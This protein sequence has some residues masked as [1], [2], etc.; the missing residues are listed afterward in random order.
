MTKSGMSRRQRARVRYM[1]PDRLKAHND[2]C[3]RLDAIWATTAGRKNRMHYARGGRSPR[4]MMK[5]L[6]GTRSRWFRRG[7]GSR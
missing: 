1:T 7:S 2:G 3:K 6:Q 4:E 5:I